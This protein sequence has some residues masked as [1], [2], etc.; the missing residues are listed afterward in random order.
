MA[1]RRT[2]ARTIG[3]LPQLVL[4]DVPFTAEQL[5]LMGRYPYAERWCGIAND[6]RG[7]RRRGDDALCG[8]SNSVTA[9]LVNP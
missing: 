1:G 5:V 3:H 6:R 8:A 7:A 4:G 2:R 9:E